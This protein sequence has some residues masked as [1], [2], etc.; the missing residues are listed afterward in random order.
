[1]ILKR[2]RILPISKVIQI[3]KKW[4]HIFTLKF[5]HECSQHFNLPKVITIH[6]PFNGW[7]DTCNTVLHV[8]NCALFCNKNYWSTDTCYNIGQS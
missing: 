7:M 5:I 4:K 2:N 6:L 3:K 1:M 8:Y